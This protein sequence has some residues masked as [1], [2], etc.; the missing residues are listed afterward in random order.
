MNKF[1]DL[2]T[3]LNKLFPPKL[4]EKWDK[5]GVQ[6]GHINQKIE[7]VFVALDLTTEVFEKAINMRA[8]LIITHHPFIWEDTFQENIDNAPYKKLLHDRLENTGIALFSIHTN[9][10]KAKNGMA[11][12]VMKKI[13]FENFINIKNSKYGKVANINMNINEIENLF[14]E[15]IGIKTMIQANTCYLKKY[16]KLIILPGSGDIKDIINSHKDSSNLIVTSDIKW[17]DWI[18]IEELKIPVLEVTHGIESVF[19]KYIADLIK[20]KFKKI[21]VEYLNSIEIGKL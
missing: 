19:S 11:T 14:K 17:S 4:A 6:Y 3:S 13:G 7:R 21:D 12:Q 15:K 5:I 20:T 16:K 18:T 9:F 1:K 10:D 8:D 2:I